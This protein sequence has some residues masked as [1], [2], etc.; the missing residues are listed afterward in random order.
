LVNHFSKKNF[1]D[2]ISGAAFTA[3]AFVKYRLDIYSL[4]IQFLLT[5]VIL[6]NW[7]APLRRHQIVIIFSTVPLEGDTQK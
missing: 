4:G 3:I 6:T 1:G 2:L 5:R 7:L